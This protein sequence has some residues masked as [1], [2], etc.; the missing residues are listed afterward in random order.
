MPLTVFYSWQ[1]DTP[2]RVN[3][4][5][6]EDAL[7][8]ALKKV[9]ADAEVVN[10]ARGEEV[11][12]EKD[13]KGLPGTPPI[14]E[15]IFKRIDQCSVFV[16]DLTFVAPT[17]TGRS[18]PNANVLIE[19]GWALKSRG[20]ER[21]VP[22]MND[23]FGEPSASNLPFNMRHLRWP[24]RYTLHDGSDSAHRGEIRTQLVNSL[25]TAIRSVLSNASIQPVPSLKFE[26]TKHTYDKAVF[27]GPAETLAVDSEFMKRDKDLFVPEEGA[28]MFLRLVPTVQTEEVTSSQARRLAIEGDLKP[29]T[30]R[31]IIGGEFYDRNKFG[32]VTYRLYPDTP[33]IG[34]L[35]QLFK[36]K[37]CGVS[38]AIC[39]DPVMIRASYRMLTRIHLR[40]HLRST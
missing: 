25:T 32:S 40:M 4:S 12:L 10:S 28:K 15:S 36:T 2:S 37:S 5:F 11:M 16:P 9:N 6:I 26:E 1:S 13:T 23:A 35:T 39:G 22:L 29:F 20:H 3:R 34:E 33:L 38:R 7:N 14:V 27:F 24:L 17:A 8:K 18:T 31:N 30:L 21:I 19:Y